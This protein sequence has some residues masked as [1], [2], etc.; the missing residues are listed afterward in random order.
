MRRI[1]KNLVPNLHYTYFYW[2]VFWYLCK[3][4][5]L[6][7]WKKQRYEL[8]H[9]WL[10][11]I[12]YQHDTH[13]S[14]KNYKHLIQQIL[15]ENET[16]ASVFSFFYHF[17]FTNYFLFVIHNFSKINL[18]IIAGIDYFMYKTVHPTVLIEKVMGPC[19]ITLNSAY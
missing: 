6:E 7:S 4:N 13:Y 19:G 8:V 18:Y 2:A 10:H 5:L 16:K 17:Y 11:K 1:Y 15:Q 9:N 14:Y 12:D 3:G